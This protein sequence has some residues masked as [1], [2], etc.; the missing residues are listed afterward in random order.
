MVS[1]DEVA[2]GAPI[3]AQPVQEQTVTQNPPL[4]YV[5]AEEELPYLLEE[6]MRLT[7]ENAQLRVTCMKLLRER[8]SGG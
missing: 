4:N 8:T 5:T 2:N 6:I 3:D 1:M 7:R